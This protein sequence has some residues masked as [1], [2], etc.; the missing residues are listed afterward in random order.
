MDE[1]SFVGSAEVQERVL[2][3]LSDSDQY[4]IEGVL[5]YQLIP[6]LNG[7]GLGFEN[8]KICAEA[9]DEFTLEQKGKFDIELLKTGK[10]TMTPEYIK[11]K[12]GTEVIE[13]TE[14]IDT[15][16][17]KVKNALEKYYK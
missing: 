13:V 9:E 17:Q 12:Y 16:I 2:K 7:L 6:L 8:L 10:F 11:E 1:K 15:G 5:N 14:P 4:F 3:T